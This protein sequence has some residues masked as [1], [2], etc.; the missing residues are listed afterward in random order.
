M[1]TQTTPLIGLYQVCGT[2]GNVGTPGAPI[3]HFNLLVHPSTHSVTGVVHI[4]QAIAP[5]NGD[6]V[7][8][9]VTGRIYS[10]GLGPITQIVALK[11]TYTQSFPPPAIGEIVENF[12]AHLAIDNAWDGK[13]GFEYGNGAHHIENVPVKHGP[14]GK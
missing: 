9:N 10:T 6:I 2:V 12:S 14:C 5:P 13:G 3:M 4:T 1:S 7:I 8:S 11:G